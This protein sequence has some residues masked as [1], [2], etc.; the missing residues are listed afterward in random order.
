MEVLSLFRPGTR[1]SLHLVRC[2]LLF[3]MQLAYVCSIV[4]T[5]S[6]AGAAST[7]ASTPSRNMR[8]FGS[9]TSSKST[10]TSLWYEKMWGPFLNFDVDGK[11]L[12]LVSLPSFNSHQALVPIFDAS[13]HPFTFGKGNFTE[14]ASLPRYKKY[15]DPKPADL[16]KDSI[17]S[18]FFSINTYESTRFPPLGD[19]Q[20]QSS[21]K[22]N[23]EPSTSTV[24]SLNLQ[25]VVYHG[26]IPP[27]DD[28]D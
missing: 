7:P 20:G 27:F 6:P 23:T 9:A 8:A 16:P 5:S 22:P 25:F 12:H 18:V 15:G 21:D 4:G 17:V 11:L 3:I 10:N 28:E 19:D 13:T 1:A 24:L 26:E 14:L 2:N